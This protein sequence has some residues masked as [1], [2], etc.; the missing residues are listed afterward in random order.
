LLKSLHIKA[1]RQMGTSGGGN[2]FVEFGDMELFAGNLPG[3]PEGAYMAL[4]SH[5]GS[6]GLG[7][8]I[9]RHYSAIARERCKLPRVAQHFAW[10]EMTSAEGQEYWQSMTLAGLYAQACHER[11]HANLTVCTLQPM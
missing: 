1:V 10:L 7:A 11:I 8:V 6:R 5:S 3:L 9:A 4:L 2:H